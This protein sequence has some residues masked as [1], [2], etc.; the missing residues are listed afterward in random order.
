MEEQNKKGFTKQNVKK[1]FSFG[2][3]DLIWT[4]FFI[5]LFLS[6]WAYKVD[7][8]K[9]QELIGDR[10]IRSCLLEKYIG[11]F[12]QKNPTK[13]ITCDIETMKC[14]V[15][16][17]NVEKDWQINYSDLDRLINVSDNGG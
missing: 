16:G 15:S 4:F 9:C 5:L 7:I 17:T 1:L 11:D 13:H 6:I 3:D 10:C 14:T 12:R 2:W 8:K